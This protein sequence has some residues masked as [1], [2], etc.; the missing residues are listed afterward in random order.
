MLTYYFIYRLFYVTFWWVIIA[1]ISVLYLEG[2]F[3]IFHFSSLS[4]WHF[5]WTCWYHILSFLLHL[6][7]R[8]RRTI[9]LLVSTSYG[10]RKIW[11]TWSC[12]LANVY[13]DNLY[14]KLGLCIFPNFFSSTLDFITGKIWEKGRYT[15]WVCFGSRHYL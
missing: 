5:L 11:H 1:E 8:S 9:F 6:H 12:T 15:A 10:Y 13:G 3:D 14:S 2:L 4:T 7:Q